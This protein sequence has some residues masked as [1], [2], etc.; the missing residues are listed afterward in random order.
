MSSSED[1]LSEPR[2]GGIVGKVFAVI[3]VI[4][5]VVVAGGAI[6]PL[7][8]PAAQDCVGRGEPMLVCA[9]G[10][11]G[12][13]DLSV[14]AEKDRALEAAKADATAKAA[15]AAE[16]EKRAAELDGRVKDL[17]GALAGAKTAAAEV[18]RL[19]GEIARRDARIAELSDKLAGGARK[20]D[21]TPAAGAKPIAPAAVPRPA[22][23]Q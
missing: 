3:G 10:A 4:A 13:I 18:D 12:L 8:V 1:V 22:P 23:K 19:K 2:G 20:P 6:L 16:L 7:V 14:S 11:I 15:A 17:E 9:G 21:A 5:T